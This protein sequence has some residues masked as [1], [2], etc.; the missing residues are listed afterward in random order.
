LLERA[1]E[2]RR[3]VIYG[4]D[5]Q[6]RDVARASEPQPPIRS[7]LCVPIS[8]FG[9]PR[10]CLYASDEHVDGLFGPQEMRL[11]EYLSALSGAALENA[12]NLSGLRELS[13]SLERRVSERTAQLARANRELD[14]SLAGQ[15]A[16]LLQARDDA[17]RL[18]EALRIKDR[19]VSMVSHELRTPLTSIIG[20][21]DTLLAASVDLTKEQQA[22]FLG[23]V[24]AQ[25]HRLGRL[26]DELLTFSRI[27]R[28]AVQPL[29]RPTPLLA[30]IRDVVAEL[31][32][33]A[34]VEVD[35]SEDLV[36]TMSSDHI[37][38]VLTNLLSNAERYGEPPFEVSGRETDDF[39][40][41]R[42]SD[43]GDGVSPDFVPLLFS[44]FTRDQRSPAA[45]G[46][47]FVLGLSIVV[48][49]ANTYG[50]E[51]TYE[52][53]E[54]HGASFVVRIPRNGAANDAGEDQHSV[55][56][57]EAVPA[58]PIELTRPTSGTPVRTSQ[59][60]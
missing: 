56:A 28:G 49:L 14:A 10:G 45:T 21:S 25:A 6:A 57:Q 12:G 43:H 1:F 52:P 22:E 33:D 20:F 60:P 58:P 36:I 11:A 50:G 44:E 35:C 38:Q 39:V 42:V 51:V 54:P 5:D 37:T 32:L 59:S 15:R 40:E 27:Q 23:I 13:Q 34:G 29:R 31:N 46:P 4:P 26:V 3:A 17:R 41:L 30:T 55:T 19:F 9:Y 48:A 53:V 18:E 24:Q 8:A 2:H 7:A 47:G 16:A